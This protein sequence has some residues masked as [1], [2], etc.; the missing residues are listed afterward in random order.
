MQYPE[1]QQKIKKSLQ[2]QG[3]TYGDLAKRVR[4]SESGIKKLFSAKDISLERLN[5]I[6]LALGLSPHEVLDPNSGDQ[7]VGTIELGE[8][9]QAF[10]LKNQDCFQFYFLL[11]TEPKTFPEILS[12]YKLS[13]PKAYRYLKELEKLKLLRWLPGDQ[14]DLGKTGISLFKY[15][16]PFLRDLIKRWSLS[17]V[18]EVLDAWGQGK[19]NFFTSRILY[20]TPE[21]AT[22]LSRSLSDLISEFSRRSQREKKMS[23]QEVKPL[24]FLGVL[25]EGHFVKKLN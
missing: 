8:K 11:Y 20:L 17:L 1:V 16:G 10:F 7:P 9:A 13:K 3:L 6:C 24:R 19:A 12:D 21:S 25:G 23:R 22:E 14:I 5:Q 4:M 2:E 15:E 18:T